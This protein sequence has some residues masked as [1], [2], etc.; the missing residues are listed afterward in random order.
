MNRTKIGCSKCITDNYMNLASPLLS[1]VIQ[2]P[3]TKP[4]SQVLTKKWVTCELIFYS[5][6]RYTYEKLAVIW[7]QILTRILGRVHTDHKYVRHQKV[8]VKVTIMSIQQICLHSV[9]VSMDLQEFTRTKECIIVI[10]TKLIL[11]RFVHKPISTID[12]RYITI[13]FTST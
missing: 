11:N 5:R 10:N 7:Q 4:N 2:C 9:L 3:K 13:H 1:I 12:A 8:V 6:L